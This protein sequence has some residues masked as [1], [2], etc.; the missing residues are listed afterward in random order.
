MR[1]ER[2]E[3]NVFDRQGES[4]ISVLTAA[5]L[6]AADAH[7]VSRFVT[8]PDEPIPLDERFDQVHRM[9][10]FGLPVGPDSPDNPAQHMGGQMRD[11]HPREDKESG[12]VRHP[13]KVP[14]TGLMAP[15]NEL[16]P[17]LGFPGGRTEKDAGQIA[18][19]AVAHQV[20]HV[21][22]HRAVEA[23]IVMTCEVMMKPLFFI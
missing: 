8:G 6:S 15:A 4:G 7:P 2:V 17:R 21:L 11:A 9:A 13:Q 14:G 10:V 19:L 18:S 20:L 22:S 12:I 23:Q 16:I 1:D 3:V 5:T